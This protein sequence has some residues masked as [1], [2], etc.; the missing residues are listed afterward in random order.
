MV[1]PQRFWIDEEKGTIPLQKEFIESYDPSYW[2]QKIVMNDVLLNNLE[3]IYEEYEGRL[4]DEETNPATIEDYRA[5][6]Q[7]EAVFTFYHT[8]ET[9]ITLI[10]AMQ[11][12]KIPWI[13]MMEISNAQVGSYV[14]DIILQ[15]KFTRDDAFKLF[16][17]NLHSGYREEHPEVE[18]SIAFIEEY[19]K[20]IGDLYMDKGE[21]YNH[22][23]HGLRIVMKKRWLELVLRRESEEGDDVSRQKIAEKSD[24]SMLYLEGNE[25]DWQD[26]DGEKERRW[27]LIKYIEFFDY[28][29]FY[30]FCMTNYRLIDQMFHS[31]K[32]SVQKQLNEDYDP[33]EWIKMRYFTD[34]EEVIEGLERQKKSKIPSPY[35]IGDLVY[36][37]MGESK[38]PKK[39]DFKSLVEN[40]SQDDFTQ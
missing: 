15:D 24:F 11:R 6:L 1:K 4:L 36:E 2:R 8:T 35:P 28:D 9:L 32:G 13:D 16:Y 30:E 27:G 12:N 37:P 38:F 26:S 17:P 29:L 7:A 18:E 21:K 19:L 34:L 31:L 3:D 23:K 22:Y 5:M 10:I 33:G 20:Q 25:L 39:E 14:N 40:S